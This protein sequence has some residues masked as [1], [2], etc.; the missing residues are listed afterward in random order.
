MKRVKINKRLLGL[1][2]NYNHID[3][4]TLTAVHKEPCCLGGTWDDINTTFHIVYSFLNSMFMGSDAFHLPLY[5]LLESVFVPLN[6]TL[7]F[8]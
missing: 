4:T 5:S 6:Q 2:V 8:P 1:S 3:H 7:E